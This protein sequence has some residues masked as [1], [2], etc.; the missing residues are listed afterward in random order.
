MPKTH[1]IKAAAQVKP[2]KPYPEFPLFPHATKRWAKKIKG[3]L[4]YFGPWGDPDGALQKYLEEKDDRY[5]GRTPRTT[6]DGLQVRDLVNRFLTSKKNMMEAGEIAP[7][8]FRDYHSTCKRVV[9]TFGKD[10]PVT[11]LAADDFESLKLV[12]AKTLAPVSRKTE[13]QKTRSIFKY[14]YDVAL[15]DRPIR[16]GPTFK[17][18]SNRVLQKERRRNGLKMFEA[19]ELRRIIEAAPGPLKA[20]VLLGTN[21]GFGNNDCATLQ[22]SALDLENGWVDHPRPKTGTDR[23]C[24]LWPETVVVLREVL[25]TRRTP[26]KAE[27]ADLVFVTRHGHPWVEL[28]GAGWNDAVT[29]VCRD[30]LTKLDLRRPG[31]GF[32]ALR[33]T[34]E[35]IGGESVDQVAVDHIMGHSRGD[36]ASVYR[37]RISDERLKKVADHVRGWLFPKTKNK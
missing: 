33:H 8:T 11:D 10:R 19:D 21:A 13:I 20:M 25:K 9:E 22:T 2:A 35:T 15:I 31:R 34:F 24:A 27:Y 29:R 12:M 23:R 16:F 5:A 4:Y 14:A 18:P 26:N 36:M 3:K 6:G 28:R 1:S 7:R 37:E 32:Y 30:L 17:A